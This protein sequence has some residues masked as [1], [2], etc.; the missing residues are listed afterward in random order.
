M[1]LLSCPKHRT[2]AFHTYIGNIYRDLKPENVLL[3]KTETVDIKV[4]DYGTSRL[5]EHNTKMDEQYGT[6]CIIYIYIY[7]YNI[8]IYSLIILPQKYTMVHIQKNV[9]YGRAE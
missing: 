6:V 1:C 2:Q 9:I 5:F 8:Y 7:M 4:I 3:E